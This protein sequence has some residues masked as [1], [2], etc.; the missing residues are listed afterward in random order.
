MSTE[1]TSAEPTP[2]S[3]SKA[4]QSPVSLWTQCKDVLSSPSVKHFIAGGVAG[5]VS[6][7]VVSP[8]ERMK[9]IFQVC[10]SLPAMSSLTIRYKDPVIHPTTASGVR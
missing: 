1:S 6:R 9:I 2:P 10:K 4:V 3:F 7:T 8:L 5:A